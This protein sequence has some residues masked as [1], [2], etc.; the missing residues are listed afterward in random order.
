MRGRGRNTIKWRRIANQ[1]VIDGKRCCAKDCF[2]SPL[3]CCGSASGLNVDNWW[4]VADIG[5]IPC[6]VCR[7]VGVIHPQDLMEREG[8]CEY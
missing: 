4:V 6:F 8:I 5:M 3:S 1:W 2:G 7:C